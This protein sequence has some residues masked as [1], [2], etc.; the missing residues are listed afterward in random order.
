MIY[1]FKC[2]IMK[3]LE[4]SENNYYLKSS[5]S[6][7]KTKFEKRLNFLKKKY[8]LFNEISNFLN[9]LIDNTKDVFIFCAGNS[10]ISK[11]IKSDK[12]LINEIDENY[13]IEYNNNITYK[14]KVFEEEMSNFDNIGKYIINQF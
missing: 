11:N 6:F 14:D 9:N 7:F 2:W 4:L 10:I 5:I 12:I 13:K 1:F 3:P 8:F